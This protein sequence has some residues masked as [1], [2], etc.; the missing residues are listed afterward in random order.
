MY[1]RGEVYK[2][3]I[4]NESSSLV[5][6]FAVQDTRHGQPSRSKSIMSEGYI[7]EKNKKYLPNSA[8]NE[9]PLHLRSRR[10]TYL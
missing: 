2:G 7:K 3:S 4:E 6:G 8:L 5:V 1:G 9:L 10:V